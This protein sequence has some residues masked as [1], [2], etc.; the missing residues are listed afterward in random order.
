MMNGIYIVP[1]KSTNASKHIQTHAAFITSHIFIHCW[2]GLPRKFPTSACSASCSKSST[3]SQ[4]VDLHTHN[5]KRALS[6]GFN[7]PEEVHNLP[8]DSVT[9]TVSFS[10]LLTFVC[11]L[12]GAG[13]AV[14]EELIRAFL[15]IMNRKLQTKLRGLAGG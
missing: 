6:L 10:E 11:V 13:R 7:F 4:C 14:H 15:P 5:N 12:F 1:F 3:I 2:Q 8:T 9:T